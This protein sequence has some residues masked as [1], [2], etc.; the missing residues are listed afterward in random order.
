MV[1]TNTPDVLTAATADLTLALLLA[2]A[3]RVLEG[4]ALARSGGWRGWRPDKDATDVVPE[5]GAG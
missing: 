4:M 2:A 3:R 1:V 5:Y